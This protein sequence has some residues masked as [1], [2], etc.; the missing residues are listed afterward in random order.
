MIVTELILWGTIGILLHAV[1]YAASSWQFWCFIGTYWAVGWIAKQQ[2]NL[3]GIIFFLN[4]TQHDQDRL[5]KTL[6]EKD[7]IL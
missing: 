7:L 2:G 4:M 6:K 5:R 3:Q 1:G